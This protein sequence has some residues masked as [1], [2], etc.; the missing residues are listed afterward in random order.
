MTDEWININPENKAIT[1]NFTSMFSS[2]EIL[3]MILNSE[4]FGLETSFV[5]NE[6]NAYTLIS[7]SF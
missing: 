7:L 6:S 2:N 1:F 5:E 4:L 3:Q